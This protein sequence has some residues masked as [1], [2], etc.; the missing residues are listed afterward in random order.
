[1]IHVSVHINSSID[2]KTG[3][4]LLA[5][6]KT[7]FDEVSQEDGRPGPSEI[8]Q[9]VHGPGDNFERAVSIRILTDNRNWVLRRH[10]QSFIGRIIKELPLLKGQLSMWIEEADHTF[11]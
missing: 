11:G 3:R 7:Y 6:I 10:G 4:T 1:M 2:L 9:T 5:L 8:Q